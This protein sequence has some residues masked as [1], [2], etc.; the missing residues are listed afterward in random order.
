[1]SYRTS[2]LGQWDPKNPACG[3]TKADRIFTQQMLRDLGFVGADLKPLTIDGDWGTNSSAAL[4][5]YSVARGLGLLN[6]AS[7]GD[8]CGQLKQ[9]WTALKGGG[10]PAPAAPGACPPGQYGIPPFCIGN[11]IPGQTQP[12]PAPAAPGAC[13]PGQYGIPPFCI[14]NPIPGPPSPPGPDPVPVTKTDTGMSKNTKIALGAGAALLVGVALY[15]AM[16]GKKS[17]SPAARPVRSGVAKTEMMTPNR[18]KG[19]K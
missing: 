5:M 11:P 13:P 14:G 7:P 8:I 2:G 19:A 16:S 4:A 10:A 9:E 12:P 18:K 3:T 17:S 1:M 6:K 15:A